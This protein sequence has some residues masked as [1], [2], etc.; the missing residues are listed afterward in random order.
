ME[1]LRTD[2][3]KGS[4]KKNDLVRVSV[5]GEPK[6]SINPPSQVG[7]ILS[8]IYLP[9]W[10]FIK[11]FVL[12]SQARQLMHLILSVTSLISF[13]ISKLLNHFH[14][15]FAVFTTC[16]IITYLLICPPL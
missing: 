1:D 7:S 8:S 10:T 6:M 16:L 12:S 11:I 2:K 13:F 14:P 9:V 4:G 3:F 15:T 5:V